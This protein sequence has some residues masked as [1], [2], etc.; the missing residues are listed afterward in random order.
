MAREYLLIG[1]SSFI[2]NSRFFSVDP[3]ASAASNVTPG[4]SL[5]PANLKNSTTYRLL[6]SQVSEFSTRELGTI[7]FK[8]GSPNPHFSRKVRRILSPFTF[9]VVLKARLRRFGVHAGT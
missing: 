8:P 1:S 7:S 2:G 9:M 5:I 6:R 4:I 3:T